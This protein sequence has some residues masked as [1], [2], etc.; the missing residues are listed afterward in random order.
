MGQPSFPPLIFKGA[1]TPTVATKITQGGGRA[2]ISL[3][4][5]VYGCDRHVKGGMGLGKCVI[6]VVSHG[7]EYVDFFLKFVHI[8]EW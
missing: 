1:A 4:C 3:I 5:G 2:C 6:L 8:H 7:I